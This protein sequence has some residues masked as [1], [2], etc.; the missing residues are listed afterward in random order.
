MIEIE[1]TRKM[2]TWVN[3]LEVKGSCSEAKQNKSG[4]VD[5]RSDTKLPVIPSRLSSLS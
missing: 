2:V 5:V 4:V 1:S 3:Y